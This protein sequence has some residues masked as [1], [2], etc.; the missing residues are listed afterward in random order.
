MKGLNVRRV[1]NFNQL[2][3]VSERP[4]IGKKYLHTQ[5]FN[6]LTERS[7]SSGQSQKRINVGFGKEN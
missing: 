6:N 2:K 5:R 3:S 1:S 4:E 7:L